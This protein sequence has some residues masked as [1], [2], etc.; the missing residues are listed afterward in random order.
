MTLRIRDGVYEGPPCQRC[1]RTNFDGATTV[2]NLTMFWRGGIGGI[3]NPTLCRD[4]IE[5]IHSFAEQHTADDVHEH[6]DRERRAAEALTHVAHTIAWI[7]AV[8]DSSLSPSTQ[9][10]AK[11]AAQDLDDVRKYIA[12]TLR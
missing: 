3:N 12:E 1:G 6:N 5:A 10:R 7:D 8:C 2:S 11:Q 9:T 4:C